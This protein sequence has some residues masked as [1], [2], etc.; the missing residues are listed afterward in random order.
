M[1]IHEQ[2]NK[3]FT[4]DPRFN[5]LPAGDRYLLDSGKRQ[6]KLNVI[7]TGVIGQEHMLVTYLE[8]RAE[9]LGIHD[10]N[11]GSVQ[12]AQE[13][14]KRF[15]P[16]KALRVYDSLHA[17]CT[18]PDCDGLLICTP[19]YTH[20]DVVKTAVQSSTAILLEKPIATNLEDAFTI[21]EIANNYPALFQIGLQ[22]RYKAIYQEAIFE[23]LNRQTL[24]DIKTI[25]MIEHRMPFSR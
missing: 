19:N 4:F 15:N 22:Y 3:S 14:Q 7:G 11:P 25:S 9:I 23:A 13:I 5:Y 24:G 12:A 10:P 20:I 1:K 18:D 2:S 16:D 8:G 21:Y 17:A 6:H